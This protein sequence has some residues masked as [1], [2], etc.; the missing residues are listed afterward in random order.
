M[1]MKLEKSWHQQLSEEIEKP[2]VSLLK[3]FLEKE[4]E[5]KQVVFPPEPLIFNAFLHTP[6]D[7]VKAVIIGQDPYHGQGQAHGLS[8]SV[9]EGVRFPPS[10]KNVFLELEQD[11]QIPVSKQ[12]CLLAWAKQGVLMLNATLTVRSGKPRSHYGKGW[13]RFTDAVVS[14][15]L[16]RKDPI[17]FLLW[18]KA[19]QEKLEQMQ[20]DS[21][22]AHV[23][24]TAAHP[25]PYSAHAGFFGCRHFS[26]ANALLEKWGQKPIDW[27]LHGG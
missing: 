22:M 12:G 1:A 3:E 6:F 21:Q 8:F 4:K 24:L 2:Y 15:L 25:S 11:L 23:A 5:E 26:K 10:L 27:R 9:P 18:G 14:K 16:E 13:E 17:V 19:A 20:G 7:Q